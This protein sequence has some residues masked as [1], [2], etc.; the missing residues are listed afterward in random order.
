[1]ENIV[2]YDLT[3]QK[4]ITM[5]QARIPFFIIFL[6]EE[7]RE[8]WRGGGGGDRQRVRDP[9]CGG[10]IRGRENPPDTLRMASQ[11]LPARLE[12]RGIRRFQIKQK[13]FP[14]PEYQDIHFN[15][16]CTKL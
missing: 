10:A 6:E 12:L 5:Q 4:N 16:S 8:C 11:K 7:E 9:Y 2:F 3:L 15:A 1:M 14:D 13:K